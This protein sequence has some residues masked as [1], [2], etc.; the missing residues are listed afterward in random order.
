MDQSRLNCILLIYRPK[1]THGVSDSHISSSNR[2]NP[3]PNLKG[4]RQWDHLIHLRD[5]GV[6]EKHMDEDERVRIGIIGCA[7]I[8]RKLCRAISLSPN[9]ILW[10]IGSRSLDKAKS[11]ASKNGLSTTSVR[12]YGSYEEVV[13]DPSVDA[14][15]L[16]LPTS[17]HVEWAFLAA[18]CKKHILLE[19]PVAL[20]LPQLDQIL[21]VC[22]SNGVQFMDGTMWLHHPRTLSMRKL[23]SDPQHFGRLNYVRIELL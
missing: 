21:E 17:L 8:A 13:E 16:P 2:A 6:G 1:E 23:L 14:V 10:A 11:F 5:R 7:E 18:Q 20:D 19:K 12:L 15:Y 4:K 3:T 22:S 9:A